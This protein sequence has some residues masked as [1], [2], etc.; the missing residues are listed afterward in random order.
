MNKRTWDQIDDAIAAELQKMLTKG[1][2][3]AITKI[4]EKH[5][6]HPKGRG[7]H[8]RL[9]IDSKICSASGKAIRRT[10]VAELMTVDVASKSSAK[11][12]VELVAKLKRG[13]I[14]PR[15]FRRTIRHMKAKTKMGVSFARMTHLSP[16]IK[17]VCSHCRGSGV[18][19]KR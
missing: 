15:K 1:Q 10:P 14:S 18:N 2:F 12:I 11:I 7:R 19:F 8:Y 13:G 4:I 3:G 16:L 5:F 6:R 9:A 17:G